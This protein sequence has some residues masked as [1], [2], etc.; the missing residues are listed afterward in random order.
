MEKEYLRVRSRLMGERSG[1]VNSA[2][3][4]VCVDEVALQALPPFHPKYRQAIA[5][6]TGEWSTGSST[7]SGEEDRKS[8]ILEAEK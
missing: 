5:A 1:R 8:K 3:S 6:R 4:Q 7:S 2:Q